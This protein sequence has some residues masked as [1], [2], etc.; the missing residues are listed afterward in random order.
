MNH[1]VV[2][3]PYLTLAQ[4]K[5]ELA[6][7]QSLKDLHEFPKSVYTTGYLD[8]DMEGLVFLTD[9]VYLKN[10]INKKTKVAYTLYAQVEG[11]PSNKELLQVQVML[12]QANETYE[13][14]RLTAEPQLPARVPAIRSRE[15]IPT[16]W[17]S[18]VC[19]VY[20]PK[21]IRKHLAQCGF[22]VLRLVCYYIN[23]IDAK[24]MGSGDVLMLIKADAYRGLSIPP[25][26][27]TDE[28]TYKMTV[29]KQAKDKRK[30]LDLIK[31]KQAKP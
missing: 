31:K 7:H 28:A 14:K 20:N 29:A 11:I 2:Y 21:L 19:K 30:R 25:L 10:E 24:K 12:T 8:S 9:D 23:K 16:T 4:F 3:K 17:V 26:S 22:P 15:N 27:K 18:I 13:V 6:H 1:F 5:K